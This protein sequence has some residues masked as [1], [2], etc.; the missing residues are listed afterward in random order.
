MSDTEKITV[1][2]GIVDLGRIDLLVQEGFYASRA[3]F[4]RTA[5]RNQLERQKTA[6]DSITTRK[7]MVIGTLSFNRHELDQKREDNE[8]INVKVIGMFILTDDV[9][10]QLALDTIQS[11]TVRG[12]FKA[13]EDVKDALKDRLR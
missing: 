5:I 13:P 9:T 4:V 7:S 12:V 11:V 6:V 2:I 8:M 1:N 10:P 3:D